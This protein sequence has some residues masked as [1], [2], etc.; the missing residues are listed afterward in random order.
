[1]KPR[2]VFI[3]PPKVLGMYRDAGCLPGGEETS[4]QKNRP[5]ESAVIEPTI[6][7]I[8]ARLVEQN[9]AVSLNPERGLHEMVQPLIPLLSPQQGAA[10]DLVAPERGKDDDLD[11]TRLRGAVVFPL[12]YFYLSLDMRR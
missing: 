12:T 1:M 4:P 2:R 8:S 10:E 11:S 6:Y 9:P 3:K 5:R 7:S